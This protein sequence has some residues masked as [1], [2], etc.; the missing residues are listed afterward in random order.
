ME[1]EIL[2]QKDFTTENN[3]YVSEFELYL[4]FSNKKIMTILGFT[5]N[6][7]KIYF[8]ALVL[9]AISLPL[10]K[11]TLSVS[12]ITLLTN[13]ILEGD[14][15]TKFARLKKNL[16][17]WSMILIFVVHVAWLLNTSDFS[18]AFHD[19]KNKIILVVFP[20]ILFSS[21]QLSEKE[22]RNILLW[23]LAAV[24][25]SSLI[26]TAILTGII[27]PTPSINKG[28]SIFISHIR[29]S[30]LINV[31]IFSAGYLVYSEKFNLSTKNRTILI[32]G[33]TWL[34]V[35]L[36]LLKSL[37]G[38]IIF[39]ILLFI[40]LGF[41]SFRINYIVYRLFLQ[42]ALITIFLVSASFITHSVSRFYSLENVD[43]QNLEKLTLSGNSYTHNTTDKQIENGNYLWLY[44]CE[45]EFANEWAKRSSIPITETDK[46]GQLIQYTAIRYLTSKGL[47]KDSVGVSK[48]TDQDIKNIESGLANYI[49][50]DKYSLYPRLYQVLWEFDVYKK[51]QNPAG[52]S[53]TQR[54]IFLQTA[55]K[56]VK[57]N[58]WS[59]VG[60]GDVKDEFDK[61]YEKDKSQLPQNRRLRAHNQW[62]T[63]LLTFGIFGFLIILI[64]L[65]YPLLKINAF[66]SYLFSVF[67]IIAFLSMFN[68]DTLETQT[69]VTFFSYFYTLFLT[70]KFGKRK[71][72]NNEQDD[73]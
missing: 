42:L 52:N 8:W 38:I 72:G 28:I 2:S 47:R 55:V 67:F 43:Y 62:I 13:W 53:I 73:E 27:S 61:Q 26:S 71:Q 50:A 69:G 57:N 10:S 30:L 39:F 20:F 44:Y 33:I 49:F 18:Y 6:H 64:A 46:K 25:S 68:E 7:S 12:I 37:T 51:G 1:L 5:F 58:F 17:F 36:F 70:E 34:I 56:I 60:T 59:G 11:F 24:I 15:K 41:L 21:R 9:A 4:C 19:L 35:F 29:F 66:R 65:F 23:F 3:F 54:I 16:L 32:A 22:L 31:A 14:Y 48:L 63:F 40:I 45:K